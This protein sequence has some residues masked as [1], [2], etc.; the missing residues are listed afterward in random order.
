MN[1]EDIANALFV[2]EDDLTTVATQNELFKL[3]GV[4]DGDPRYSDV[5]LIADWHE[6][7]TATKVRE[8]WD[9]GYKKGWQA[10]ANNVRDG[11]IT[12]N[13]EKNGEI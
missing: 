6:R 4:T 7:K 12:L 9:E 3:L 1:N 8:A 2:D 5:L 10:H 11:H 13:Q